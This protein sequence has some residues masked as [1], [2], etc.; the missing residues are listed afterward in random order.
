MSIHTLEKVLWDLHA[1]P[2]KLNFYKRNPEEFLDAY[3]LNDE[4]RGLLIEQHVRK[5]ADRGV[6]QMLLFV[7]WQAVNGGEASIPEYMKRMNT[8]AR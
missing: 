8:P 6:S 4:E 5:M 1:D 7:N 2:E 3:P